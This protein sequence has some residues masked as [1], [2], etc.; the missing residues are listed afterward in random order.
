MNTPD[1]RSTTEQMPVV[2]QAG[3]FRRPPRRA[4][5]RAVGLVVLALALAAVGVS[6]WKVRQ[7]L[8][9]GLGARSESVWT[10]DA[11][12]VQLTIPPVQDTPGPTV[13]VLWPLS[14]NLLSGHDDSTNT[15]TTSTTEVSTPNTVDDHGVGDDDGVNDDNGVDDDDTTSTTRPRSTTS[16]TVDD[17]RDGGGH[18]SDDGGGDRSGRRGGSD[19]GGDDGVSDRS[20]SNSGKG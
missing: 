19:R 1:P 10:P 8:V 15:S 20:G 6:V 3:G 4:G 9:P 16:T 18:G 12:R 14:L 5:G 7:L 2:L 13:S 11:R 17:H